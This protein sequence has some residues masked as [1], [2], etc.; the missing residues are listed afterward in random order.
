MKTNI[1]ANV[2]EGSCN[3]GIIQFKRMLDDGASIA[4]EVDE[5][6]NWTGNPEY[7]AMVK[8][9]I[10]Q[11]STP[12]FPIRF[13]DLPRVFSGKWFWFWAEVKK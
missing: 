13:E 7:I 8:L 3:V 9:T 6:W 5:S 1:F 11:L 10:G 2:V 12:N 4:C